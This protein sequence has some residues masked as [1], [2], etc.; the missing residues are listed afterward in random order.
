MRFL[1]EA[2]LCVACLLHDFIQFRTLLYEVF[3]AL[4]N[5]F[6]GLGKFLLLLF[7]LDLRLLNLLV[8]EF[9][10]QR[11]EL[12]L[13]CQGVVFTV[14]AHVVELFLVAVEAVLSQPYVAL[15]LVNGVFVVLDLTLYLLAACVHALYF[16]LEVFHFKRKFTAH[17]TLLVNLRKCR[18]QLEKGFE[19]FLNI[20]LCL[21][22]CHN[23]V[24]I[25]C[26]CFP[27]SSFICRKTLF[28]HRKKRSS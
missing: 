2:L 26:V 14:V 13:L 18:L 6:G 7:Y 9:N 15:L 1:P 16:I 11:L 25:L 22:L 4:F 24:F 28:T 23:I 21:F 10:L 12:D 17:G 3:R 5:H 20:H 8:A 27:F 19:L